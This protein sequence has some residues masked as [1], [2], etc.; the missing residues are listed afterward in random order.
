V[1]E[2]NQGAIALAKNPV[3]RQRCKHVDVKFHFVRSVIK[4]G[5]INLEYCPT[6]DMVADVLTKPATKFKLMKFNS[7]MFGV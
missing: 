4:E 1:Y 3:Y 2:D 7:F 6:D 5:R